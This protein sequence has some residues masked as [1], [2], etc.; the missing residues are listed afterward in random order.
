VTTTRLLV[1]RHG[2]T[3]WS[4]TRLHTGRSDIELNSA[5]EAQAR[6]LADRLPLADVVAIWC[7]P[8]SRAMESARLAGL[9]VDRVEPDLIEWDYGQADGR[10]TAEIRE[11]HP[12]W[13]IWDDANLVAETVTDVGARADK[14]IA[15]AMGQEELDGT[16]ALVSHAHLLRVLAARW[17]GLPAVAGRHLTLDAAGWGR[18]GWERETPVIECWNPPAA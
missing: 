9:V 16:V 6:A 14:V 13:T 4:Q 11:E 1:V 7:S 10:T 2:E 17:L 15:R 3:D 5:G 12:G 8:L 18:L